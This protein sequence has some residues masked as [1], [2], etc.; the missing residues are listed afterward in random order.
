MKILEDALHRA[1]KE[2]IS[3]A[4]TEEEAE[5]LVE[6]FPD[7]INEILDSTTNSILKSVK[8]NAYQGGLEEQRKHHEEFKSRNYTRWKDGFDAL[9]LLISLCIEAGSDLNKQMRPHAA[10]TGNLLFDIL[11]RLHAKACLIAREIYC[12]LNNGFADAAHSRWRALHEI[13][14]TA[15]FLV[16]SG[17]EIAARYSDHEYVDSYKGANQHR[18]YAPRL[19]AETISDEDLASLKSSYDEVISLYGAEFAKPYG[20]ADQALA[21]K[22]VNFSDLE[23]AVSLDHWRP[24]YKWAS[25]NVHASAKSIRTSLGTIDTTDDLLLVGSSDS[26]MADPGHSAAISLSQITTTLLNLAPN[27]DRTV[28]MKMI[29]ILSTEV[30][31]AFLK[32]HKAAKDN[33]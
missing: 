9:E 18:K 33:S 20:W 26:G 31:E 21:K 10:A 19:K 3:S 16:K 24:Y 27:I 4:K 8:L 11:T 15:M 1:I 28:M 32:A 14:V 13:T 5:S 23:L 17:P 25:Q 7:K 29:S 6:Q 12:L 30:G 2:L 22:N